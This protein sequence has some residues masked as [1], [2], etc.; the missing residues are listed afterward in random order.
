[1][2][3]ITVRFASLDDAAAICAIYNQGIVDRVATLETE[4]RDADERR[5]WL[6]SRSSR[7][8]VVV[9]ESAGRV[10]A[11]ASLNSFNPRRC[12][13]HVADISVYVERSWRGKGVGLILLGRLV[14]LGRG[15]GFHKL[16]LACFPTNKA[17]VA[18]YERMGFVPVGVYREQGLLD[19]QWVDVLIMEQLL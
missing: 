3:P 19:G 5:R 18:L 16:V 15:L 17:G 2:E 9:A 6:G 10:I 8:P 11:W 13:D 4:L 1:M 12:Y 7:Y 14:E